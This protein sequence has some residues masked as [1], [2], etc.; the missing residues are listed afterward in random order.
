[1]LMWVILSSLDEL[2]DKQD[3]K[4]FPLYKDSEILGKLKCNSRPFQTPKCPDWMY[5]LMTQ[6]WLYNANERASSESILECLTLRCPWESSILQNWLERH[7]VCENWPVLKVDNNVK[8]NSGG[9][10]TAPTRG[11]VMESLSEDF[12]GEHSYHY[13]QPSW[14]IRRTLKRLGNHILSIVPR[15]KSSSKVQKTPPTVPYSRASSMPAPALPDEV[16]H[17]KFQ[18][19]CYDHKEGPMQINGN[20]S[21][22]IIFDQSEEDDDKYQIPCQSFEKAHYA[23]LCKPTE[24]C[25]EEGMLIDKNKSKEIIYEQCD[26]DIDKYQLPCESLEKPHYANLG[27]PTESCEKEAVLIDRNKSKEIIY[28]QCD[29]DEHIYQIPFESFEKPHYANLGKPTESCKEEGML[30]DE[31]KSKEI[32]YEQ[33]DEEGV[34]QIPCLENLHYANLG[35]PTESCHQKFITNSRDS[36][37]TPYACSRPCIARCS[38]S[39]ELQMENLLTVSESSIQEPPSEASIVKQDSDKDRLLYDDVGVYDSVPETSLMN[40]SSDE[41]NMEGENQSIQELSSFQSTC[42]ALGSSE[43]LIGNF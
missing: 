32:I 5:V 16:V 14:S 33:C 4:P 24:I 7:E 27:K 13:A 8:Q 2:Y 37:I 28:E 25:Q 6:C 17:V 41:C 43:I 15:I 42:S 20:K 18:E 9:Q 35:K 31:N 10:L 40:D 1:M 26:E 21:K 3:L 39:A 29:E 30:I 11:D 36:S 38:L 23:N 12:F 22:G 19:R 34:Y